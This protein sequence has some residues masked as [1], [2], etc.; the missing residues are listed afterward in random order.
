[1]ANSMIRRALEADAA[2]LAACIDAA[3]S[4]Y[5][6]RGIELPAVSDGVAD[7]IRNNLVWVA[8]SGGCIL[9]GLILVVRTDHALL[10]NLA[11]DPAATGQGLGRALLER[12]EREVRQLNLPKLTLRTHAGIPEN[13]RL[14][15][16]L[17]WRVAGRTGDTVVLEKAL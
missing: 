14:Y 13:I 4:V 10:A 7:D 2:A 12:A 15:E 11:V 17:G 1:M 6:G 9:G 16:H 3:Y 5:R 8:D